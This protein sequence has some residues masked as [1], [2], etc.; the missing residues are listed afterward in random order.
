GGLVLGPL[1]KNRM[2]ANSLPAL[3]D[4]SAGGSPSRTTN[5]T[6][7]IESWVNRDFMVVFNCVGD[8]TWY[9][10]HGTKPTA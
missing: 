7:K 2:G 10:I 4:F 1:R 6:E 5:P 8:I 3:V 9:S